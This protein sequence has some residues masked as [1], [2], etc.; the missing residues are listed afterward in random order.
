MFRAVDIKQLLTYAALNF[1][2]AQR[3]LTRI[4]LFNPRMGISFSASL[5]EISLETSGCPSA[6]LLPEIVRVISSGD[7]SR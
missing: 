7:T 1:A 5:D 2:S 4:G 6:E 3:K